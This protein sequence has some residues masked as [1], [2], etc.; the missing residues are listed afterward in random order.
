MTQHLLPILLVLTMFKYMVI[1]IFFPFAT[2]TYSTIVH[3]INMGKYLAVTDT[4]GALDK[5]GYAILINGNKIRL[6]RFLGE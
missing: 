5:Y 3:K 4:C 1:F 2:R 6:S